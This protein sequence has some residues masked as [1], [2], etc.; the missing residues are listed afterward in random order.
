V[1]AKGRPLLLLLLLLLPMLLWHGLLS[2]SDSLETFFGLVQDNRQHRET[3]A[4]N[5]VYT[6]S[7]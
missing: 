1:F 2:I 7:S 6:L 4:M 3:D 5:Q